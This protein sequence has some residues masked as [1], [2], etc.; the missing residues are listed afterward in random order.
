[1][2]KG[3]AMSDLNQSHG[4]DQTTTPNVVTA[5]K[6]FITRLHVPFLSSDIRIG[7]VKILLSEISGFCEQ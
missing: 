5:K 1:M 2:R 4:I 6:A 3:M 7:V